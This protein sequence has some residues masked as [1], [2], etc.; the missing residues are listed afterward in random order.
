MLNIA[1]ILPYRWH[2][3]LFLLCGSAG[4]DCEARDG[5]TATGNIGATLTSVYQYGYYDD[6]S[7]KYGERIH[8]Q[9]RGSFALDVQGE[10]RPGRRNTFYAL[11]SFAR[12][13]GLKN[14]GGV[15]LQPNAD[16]LA[17]C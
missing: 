10:I 3:L 16:D 9:G 1:R 11:A 2:T 17:G 5:H 12:G 7:D 4:I 13:N 8:D 15:S 14:T 6:A